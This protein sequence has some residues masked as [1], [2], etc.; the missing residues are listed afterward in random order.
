M[1]LSVT[2]TILP[3]SLKRELHPL[4][5]REISARVLS[6]VRSNPAVCIRE[7]A[8]AVDCSDVTAQKHLSRLVRA[9][10][11][12]EKRIGRTRIFVKLNALEGDADS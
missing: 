5:N 8:R 7:V 1:V 3:E 11:A 10:L 12:V 4:C 6:E 9:G 2:N